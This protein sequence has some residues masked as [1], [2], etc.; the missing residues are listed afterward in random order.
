ML[1]SALLGNPV[2]HSISPTLFKIFAEKAGIE[3]AHLKINIPSK[4]RLHDSLVM[5]KD[6]GFCGIN[7]TLPYKLDVKKELD[8]ISVE[9]NKIGAVNTVVFKKNKMIGYNTDAKGALLTIE[10]K[11][12]PVLKSDKILVIGAGGAARAVIFELFKKCKNVTILNRNMEEANEVSR[13]FSFGSNKINV[14]ILSDENLEKKLKEC[15][16]IINTTSVGMYP[17]NNDRIISKK[18]FSKVKNFKGKYFFD[19]IFNPYKT[20]FLIDAEKRGA[21]ISSGTY[22][23][24]YQA[25][26]AFKLWTG[27]DLKEL[28]I[29]E[30][31]N[32]LIIALK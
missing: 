14:E 13:D 5:L 18:V 10:K 26:Y 27:I 7:V 32:D 2:D 25:I 15:N 8:E 22:M 12:R 19:V 28:K 21:R 6:L 4:D 20:T 17:M 30:I 11:L 31:N 1:Y 3:Y 29:E 23:M 24:I 9:A 16:F